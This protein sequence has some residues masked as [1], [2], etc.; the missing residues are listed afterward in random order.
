MK[1]FCIIGDTGPL[2]LNADTPRTWF[3]T[4]SAAADYAA[5]IQ[6]RHARNHLPIAQLH[7]MARLST[8]KGEARPQPEPPILPLWEQKAARAL[9]KHLNSN[10]K[11]T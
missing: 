6:L 2:V 7:V 10:Q 9:W 4:P 5:T 3:E 1:D 8:L 11:G